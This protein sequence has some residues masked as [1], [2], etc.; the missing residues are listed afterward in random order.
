MSDD[1]VMP[2]QITLL[3]AG[4]SRLSLRLLLPRGETSTCKPRKNSPG[5]TDPVCCKKVKLFQD[6]IDVN[7]FVQGL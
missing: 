3:M 7:P 1:A 2:L 6:T 5:Q 4:G